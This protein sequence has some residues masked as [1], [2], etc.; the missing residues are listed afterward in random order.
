MK[1]S[2][3]VDNG[4]MNKSLNFGGDPDHRLDSGTVFRIRHYWE[5]RK[6]V[7]DIN[8]LLIAAHTD[9]PDGGTSKT[10]LDG[11]I[12]CASSSSIDCYSFNCYCVYTG[13]Q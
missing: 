13:M 9:S 10:C 1:F 6:V 3:K 7:N 2:G 12:H 11:G 8:L 5:I 4:P